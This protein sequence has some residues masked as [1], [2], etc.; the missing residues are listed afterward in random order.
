MAMREYYQYTNRCQA[1]VL[2]GA[3]TPNHWASGRSGR[4]LLQQTPG[5]DRPKGMFKTVALLFALAVSVGL[6]GLGVDAQAADLEKTGATG[7]V[8]S[9]TAGC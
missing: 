7:E 2:R 9:W 4:I 1:S 6:T 5:L 3:R 8:Y